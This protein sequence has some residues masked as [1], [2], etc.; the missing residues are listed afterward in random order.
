MSEWDVIDEHSFVGMS[1]TATPS[2][3]DSE[4]VDGEIAAIWEHQGEPRR[5]DVDTGEE[6]LLNIDRDRVEISS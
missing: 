1:V 3:S 6:Q 2:G 5:L 4:P